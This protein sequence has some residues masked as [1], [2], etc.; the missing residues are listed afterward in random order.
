MALKLLLTRAHITD[1]GETIEINDSTGTY[2]ASSNPGGYGS[3]NLDRAD[4]G[5]R[6]FVLQKGSTG[7]VILTSTIQTPTSGTAN[8]VTH[9][10]FTNSKGGYHSYY[11][12]AARKWRNGIEYK[13]GEI[14]WDDALGKFYEAIDDH[15]S[16]ASDA[17]LSISDSA[18]WNDIDSIY[19]TEV[20]RIAIFRAAEAL[21]DAKGIMEFIADEDAADMIT[22]NIDWKIANLLLSET[23]LCNSEGE[24][25]EY[26]MARQDGEGVLIMFGIDNW[27]TAQIMYEKLYNRLY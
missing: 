5:L 24:L 14:V 16:H 13:D 1:D 18:H 4:Y 6:M 2:D 9:W 27:T 15:T 25:A 17:N 7:E 12:C 20:E 10:R 3:P 19:T 23:C 22:Y 11:L 21:T 26:E 8:T